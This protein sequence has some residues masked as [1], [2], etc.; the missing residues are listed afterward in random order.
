MVT[1][2]KGTSLLTHNDFLSPVHS[3]RNTQTLSIQALDSHTVHLHSLSLPSLG[4]FFRDFFRV[5]QSLCLVLH[6]VIYDVSFFCLKLGILFI[7]FTILVCM[8]VI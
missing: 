6:G 7:G 4:L 2:A 8:R 3:P 1:N 5:L